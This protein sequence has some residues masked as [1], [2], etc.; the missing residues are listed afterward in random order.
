MAGAKLIV[1]YP[2]PK[3]VEAFE[4]VYQKEHVPLGVAKLGGKPIVATKVV[5]SPQGI[6]PF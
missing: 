1:I 3:D 5:G 4:H 6:P 2:R